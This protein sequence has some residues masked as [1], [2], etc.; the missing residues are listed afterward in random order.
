VA[1]A[2]AFEGCAARSA[3]SVGVAQGL[4]EA[5]VRPTLIAG[6]S[7][8]AIVAALLAADDAAAIEAAWM[9]GAGAPVWVPS[10]VLGARWPLRMSDVVGDALRAAFGGR[11]LSDLPLPISIPVTHVSPLGRTR[12]MLTR[13]DEIGVVE[14]V[15]GSCF[16]PGPYS[17]VIRIDGRIAFDGA[18]QLRTP[19]DAARRMGGSGIILVNGHSRD[20]IA[21]GFPLV[22]Q[23]PVPADCRVIRPLSPLAL[24]PFD[25]DRDRN[26]EAIVCGRGR[27][28]QFVREQA[29]WL[30][31][32]S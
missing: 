31:Q 23:I 28:L 24:G 10:A 20:G 6:A 14:A 25:T 26:R 29:A 1:L 5:G 7:S 9:Y 3:F 8:G 11:M 4:H 12:R 2:I 18:W 17:R 16:I 15:L 19:I 32:A 21:T 22:R 27:A 30:S 13:N